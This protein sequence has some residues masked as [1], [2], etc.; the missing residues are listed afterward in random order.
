MKEKWFRYYFSEC[1]EQTAGVINCD[2][3]EQARLLLYAHY[4]AADVNVDNIK[5]E[6]IDS[7]KIIGNCFEV[8]YG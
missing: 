4:S 7:S 1:C 6:E 3:E 5:L 8:F 2:T